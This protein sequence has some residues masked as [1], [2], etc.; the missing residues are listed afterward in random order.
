ME[1]LRPSGRPGPFPVPRRRGRAV[2]GSTHGRG[3]HRGLRPHRDSE[4]LGGVTSPWVFGDE[5]AGVAVGTITLVQGSSFAICDPGGDIVDR[6]RGVEGTYV[7]DTRIC[8]RLADLRRR[9]AGRAPGVEHRPTVQRLVRRPVGGSGA[10]GAPG[11]V[12]R[13]WA[14]PRRHRRE[15]HRRAAVGRGQRRRRRRPG[16]RLRREGVPPPASSRWRCRRRPTAAV[17]TSATLRTPGRQSFAPATAA[18]HPRS[19]SRAAPCGGR[20]GSLPG[21]GGRPASRRSRAAPGPDGRA[22]APLR[23]AGGAIRPRG[24]PGRLGRPAAPVGE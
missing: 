20:C 10:A 14:A 17:S 9:G 13:S 22:A 8:S 23:R 15:P 11:A 6:P 4:R 24:A 3:A 1:C 7:A 12:G 16:P 2:L 18:P 5:S 19:M 21:P